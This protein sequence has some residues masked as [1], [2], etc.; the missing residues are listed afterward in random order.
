VRVL[1][2]GD[3]GRI[4]VAVRRRLEAADHEVVGFDAATGDDIR[5]PL[6]V[7]AAAAGTQVIIHLAGHPGDRSGTAEELMAVNLLGTYHVLRAAKAAGVARVVYAS[8]GKAIGMLERP[9]KYLPVDDA[10]PGLPARPYGLSKWLSEEMCEAFT[11]DTGIATICLR[12]VRVLL[13]SEWS[14]LAGEDELPPA[15]TQAAWHLCVYIDLEDTAAAF[16][17]AVSCPPTGHVRALL[18]AN[19]IGAERGSAE[20]AAEHLPGVPWRDGRPYA[21]GS[22]QALID[23]RVAHEVLGWRPTRGWDHRLAGDAVVGAARTPDA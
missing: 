1:L 10:H 18:C 6:A 17:A 2:T 4:G 22:R 19:D 5:D 11:N 9:P 14:A 12:P 3:R 23:C 15:P 20:L 7:A 13:D 21:P 8:S 16:A